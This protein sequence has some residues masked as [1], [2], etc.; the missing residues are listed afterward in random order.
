[1]AECD[2]IAGF[3]K[4]GHWFFGKPFGR[5]YDDAVLSAVYVL[6]FL[7]ES[8]R[9]LSS[10]IDALP[11]TWQSPTLGVFCADNAKYRLVEDVTQQYMRDRDQGALIG[12]F[13]I[14]DLITVNGVRFI[15]EDGSWGLVRASSNKPSLVLVAESRTSRDQLY[16]VMEHIQSRLAE[17]GQVGEYD[18]QMPLR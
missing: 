17:T 15:L 10:L 13:R 7:S 1:V 12:K 2:A 16:D 3:E 11:Q 6:R 4:A 5:G 18:Q 14:K 9:S 8:G